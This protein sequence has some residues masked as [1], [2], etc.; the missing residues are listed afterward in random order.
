MD[1]MCGQVLFLTYF[2]VARLSNLIAWI[3]F[4]NV[5]AQ[6]PV[7]RKPIKGNP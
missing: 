6:G 7:V 1:Q 2:D 4:G 3:K 5:K